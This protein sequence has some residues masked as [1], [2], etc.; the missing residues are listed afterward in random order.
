MP[1][2]HS[3]RLR[4]LTAVPE[5]LFKVGHDIRDIEL[6]SELRQLCAPNRIFVMLLSGRDSP[7]EIVRGLDAGA[8][9]YLSKSSSDEALLTRL[10]SALRIVKLRTR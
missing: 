1:E 3:L 10:R 6:I 4:H 7:D 8:D 2:N 5:P 9:E